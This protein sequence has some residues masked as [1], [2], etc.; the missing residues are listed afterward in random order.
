MP[1]HSAAPW[2]RTYDHPLPPCPLPFLDLK[3]EVATPTEG[4]AEPVGAADGAAAPASDAAATDDSAATKTIDIAGQKVVV[5]DLAKKFGL[6]SKLSMIPM[7]T[8]P[9]FTMPTFTKPTIPSIPSFNL[10]SIKEALGKG[11]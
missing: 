2:P 11:R 9:T 5:P 4:P 7:P 3:V 6:S 10:T 8:M 1:P